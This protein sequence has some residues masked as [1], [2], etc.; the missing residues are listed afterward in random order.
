MATTQTD[1][2]HLIHDDALPA[3]ADA[4]VGVGAQLVTLLDHMSASRD[5][6][7]GDGPDDLPISERLREVLTSA[8]EDP[9]AERDPRELLICARTLER[10]GRA[11]E[12]G[13]FAVPIEEQLAELAAERADEP[14]VRLDPAVPIERLAD[15]VL[16]AGLVAPMLAEPAMLGALCG[17]DE[18][19]DDAVRRTTL[20]ALAPLDD[21][22]GNA[23][24]A[25]A[26]DVLD[27]ALSRLVGA[28]V[29]DR[30]EE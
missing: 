2:D 24:V 28:L 10:V 17:E 18:R 14:Q 4:L 1:L 12:D 8:L 5:L 7:G 23:R 21:E 26:A 11:V 22:H 15:G 27:E 30:G 19:P 20:E 25:V 3:L 9:L 6:R 29:A 16:R 13:V